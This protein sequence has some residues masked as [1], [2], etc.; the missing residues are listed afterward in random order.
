VFFAQNSIEIPLYA[1]EMLT[2]AAALMKSNPGTA[3]IIEGHTDS[4]GDPA[5]NRL[6]SENRGAVV[7]NF[8]VGQGVAL[9]RLSVA[10][11]GAERPLE[12]NSTA[13]GRSKNR[14]VVIRLVPAKQG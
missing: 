14:R 9:S 3:A 1:N 6:I 8:L 5:Y 4:V 10:G 12:S 7:R 13:E 2:S 11:Y